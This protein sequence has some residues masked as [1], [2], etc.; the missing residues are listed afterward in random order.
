MGRPV[1]DRLDWDDEK[2]A[3]NLRERGIDFASARQFDWASAQVFIDDRIDYGEDRFLARGNIDG[4]LH[5][6]VYTLRG[7]NLRVISLRKANHRE[8]RRYAIDTARQGRDA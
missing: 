6:L 1:P 2:R 7:D 8:R 4:R 3:Q 5:I